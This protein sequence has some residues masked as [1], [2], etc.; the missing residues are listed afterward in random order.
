LGWATNGTAQTAATP[1]REMLALYYQV[2]AQNEQVGAIVSNV[3]LE[4]QYAGM[5]DTQNNPVRMPQV[6]ANVPW[7][8]TNTIPSFTRGT[9]TSKATDV[10]AGDFSQL[11]IGQRLGLS[12]RVLT[13]RYAEVGNVGLMA[14]WRGDVAVARPKA[15]PAIGH[16]RVRPDEALQEG[17]ERRQGE[18]IAVYRGRY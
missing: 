8:K 11:L 9:M 1:W 10:F 14:V 13:E 15:W 12:L 5:V 16:C 3:K 17:L 18:A 6:L 7:L 2:A 4:Q